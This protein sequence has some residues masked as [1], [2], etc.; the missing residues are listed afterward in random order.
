MFLCLFSVS[1]FVNI[2]RRLSAAY[3]DMKL[4]SP[5]VSEEFVA[6]FFNAVAAET[7]LLEAIFR[8]KQRQQLQSIQFPLAS[9]S[10]A[11]NTYQLSVR[12]SNDW[13]GALA[14]VC[15]N[16][17]IDD[18]RLELRLLALIELCEQS[19]HYVESVGGMKL[20]CDI[21]D[22][23]VGND[24]HAPLRNESLVVFANLWKVPIVIV[25]LQRSLSLCFRLS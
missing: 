4:F 8:D 9:M 10:V 24:W 20:L 11:G 17:D 25:D 19:R 5:S 15:S 3:S 22:D 2:C 12:E 1:A 23:L 21:V 13:L 18:V 14:I 16:D 7:R 6:L